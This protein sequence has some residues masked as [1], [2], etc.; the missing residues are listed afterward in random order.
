MGKIRRMKSE[1]SLSWRARD[2]DSWTVIGSLRKTVQTNQHVAWLAVLATVLS[3]GWF[4]LDGNIGLN[5][6]DEG[7]LWYGTQAVRLGYVPIRDF[8]AYDPGRYL[9][10]A[11]WSYCLGEGIF[12]YGSPAYFSSVLECWPGCLRLAG[13]PETGSF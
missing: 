11:V 4:L 6:A 2:S 13:F 9:W 10:T 1:Q 7:Q 3:V 5:L 8:Q 12:L